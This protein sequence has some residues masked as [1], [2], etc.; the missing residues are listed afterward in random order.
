MVEHGSVI[1]QLSVFIDNRP[2][3][4]A[5]VTRYLA[6]EG[7]DLCGLSLAESRDFGAVRIIVPNPDAATRALTEGAYHFSEVDVIVVEVPDRPGG[8]ADV[9]ERIAKEHINVEYAYC[10]VA[11]RHD[12]AIVVIRVDDAPRAATVLNAEGAHLLTEEELASL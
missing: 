10:M 5:E 4:L 3:T 2:G 8:M 12:K 6:D 11:R 1:R 7:I 9:V